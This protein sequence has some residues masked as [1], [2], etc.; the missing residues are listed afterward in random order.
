MSLEKRGDVTPR[1]E[2]VGKKLGVDLSIEELEK[3][4]GT[5]KV[6]V[7]KDTELTASA[8]LKGRV[9]YEVRVN[10]ENIITDIVSE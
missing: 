10:S 3:F 2:L 6:G 7:V 1:D 9:Q 8:E 5:T 4:L